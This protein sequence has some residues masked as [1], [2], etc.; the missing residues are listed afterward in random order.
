M[1]RPLRWRKSGYEVTVVLPIRRLDEVV[2]SR[3]A[4]AERDL[5]HVVPRWRSAFIAIETALTW[6]LAN[7][8]GM[9]YHP[10]VVDSQDLV[11]SPDST[12]AMI[13]DAIGIA[14]A[15]PD[16]IS[17]HMVAGNR[18]KS[19]SLSSKPPVHRQLGSIERLISRIGRPLYN[20]VV[21]RGVRP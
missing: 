1:M 14:V 13:L 8:A 11:D 6:T 16:P 3:I 10:I 17:R 19:L 21:R 4:R 20:S 15:A 5:G 9:L 18:M 7:L 2:R 12:I